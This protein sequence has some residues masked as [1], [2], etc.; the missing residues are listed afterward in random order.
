MQNIPA[1]CPSGKSVQT[2]QEETQVRKED[3][4][5]AGFHRIWGFCSGLCGKRQKCR[6]G[7][8][9]GTGGCSCET[10]LQH[11][12][13]WQPS[14]PCSPPTSPLPTEAILTNEP[15]HLSLVK[16]PMAVLPKLFP[17]KKEAFTPSP[18]VLPV[19]SGGFP[20]F[21][22]S[23]W[24]PLH[25]LFSKPGTDVACFPGCMVARGCGD[26]GSVPSSP[27]KKLLS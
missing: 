11:P 10:Q 6:G 26:G 24:A 17:W 25:C 13:C 16:F 22:P 23:F 5:R 12:L 15:Q 19:G 27:W 18:G 21:L 3:C 8:A 1:T 20:G 7:L 9:R 14:L 4:G 2:V